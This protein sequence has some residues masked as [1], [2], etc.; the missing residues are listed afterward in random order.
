MPWI[1][2]LIW[3]SVLL[4][5]FTSTGMLS[6]RKIIHMIES[7]SEMREES[8]G[9]LRAIGGWSMVAIWAVLTLFAGSFIG[10]WA[11][12]GDLDAALARAA[13]RLE[14]LIHILIAIAESD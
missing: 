14:I 9:L 7:S 10:D 2:P 11:Y 13:S 4:V 1:L 8:P 12:T 3:G 6:V 5:I